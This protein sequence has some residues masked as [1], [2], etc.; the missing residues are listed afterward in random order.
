MI[1][2]MKKRNNEIINQ[3]NLNV[4]LMLVNQMNQIN[5]QQSQTYM[6][7]TNN[8][9]DFGY[10]IY[11]NENYLNKSSFINLQNGNKGFNNMSFYSNTYKNS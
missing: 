9:G 3:N 4:N 1:N 8:M 7:P 5:M 11:N 6:I 10:T 2:Q